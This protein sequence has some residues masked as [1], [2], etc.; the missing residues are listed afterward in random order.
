M[1]RAAILVLAASILAANVLAADTPAEKAFKEWADFNVGGVWTSTDAQ[2]KK[3]TE[4]CE[5]ILNKT[6][7]LCTHDDEESSYMEV[8]GIEPV[9]GKWTWWTFESTGTV[10]KGTGESDKEGSWSYQGTGNG[11]AGANL[12]KSRTT[13]LAAD[14]FSAEILEYI[15]DGKK[16]PAERVI[17]T[18]LREAA[19]PKRRLATSEPAKK[20]VTA[21]E[22]VF[23]EWADYSVGGTWT[24]SSGE[25]K[26]E[27]HWQW[28]LGKAFVLL[29]GKDN[30]GAWLDI[31][32]IDPVT[33]QWTNWGMD[34]KGRV[35]NGINESRKANEWT[36]RIQ[37]QGKAGPM[38]WNA[39][40]VKLGDNSKRLEYEE[41][42][43]D[44][45][46]ESLTPVT[47]TRKQ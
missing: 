47:L 23:R 21:A 4:R 28:V 11:K 19:P 3:A 45:K 8:H 26:V 39:K 18:R 42:I 37:G 46:K 41:I 17:V 1:F 9:S 35:W 34:E 16:Q 44:G 22:K 15:K 10:W 2:G 38:V 13:K 43:V 27:E 12:W 29:K 6:F 36:Y 14:R 5:W 7:V 32:G 24:G 31:N 20:E 33:G 30:Y 40:A 25:Y